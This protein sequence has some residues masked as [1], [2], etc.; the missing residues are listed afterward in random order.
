[1]SP[2]IASMIRLQF[3]P[4]RRIKQIEREIKRYKKD[5]IRLKGKEKID[6]ARRY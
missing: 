2:N 1:M 6:K 5:R 4:L 3:D